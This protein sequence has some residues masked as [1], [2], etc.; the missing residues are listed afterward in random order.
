MTSPV[1]STSTDS[2]SLAEQRQ[3]LRERLGAQR[4]Q[5]VQQL[6]PAHEANGG[7]PRSKTMRF[8]TEH[9]TLAGS[10]FTG[11]ATL[12]VGARYLKSIA[13]AAAIIKIVRT[14]SKKKQPQR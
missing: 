11:A 9:S 8:I 3:Q 10:L 1:T 4:Q 14:A 13:A 12:L 6:E 2:A 7:Y 5:I